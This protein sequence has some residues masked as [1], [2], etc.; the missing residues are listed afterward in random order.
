MPNA[1]GTATLLCQNRSCLKLWEEDWPAM[2]KDFASF[3]EMK[4]LECSVC[5]TSRQN[6]CRVRQTDQG[7]ERHAQQP[8]IEAPYIVPFNMPKY[9]AQQL[10]AMEFH[11]VLRRVVLFFVETELVVCAWEFGT[12]CVGVASA[13]RC[14]FLSAY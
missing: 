11:Y 12:S 4:A 7:D 3:D 1:R 6:R 10:R 5:R 8:F 14:C 9:F 13:P 2:R